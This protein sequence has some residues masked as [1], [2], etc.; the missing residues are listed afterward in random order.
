MICNKINPVPIINC[1]RRVKISCERSICV[2]QTTGIDRDKEG[3][4]FEL[5]Y[6]N[7]LT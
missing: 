5:S 7:K 3:K 1:R 4:R 2:Q 6:N